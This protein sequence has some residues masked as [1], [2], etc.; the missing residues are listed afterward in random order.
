M[1]VNRI[2]VE[3]SMDEKLFQLDWLFVLE[4]SVFW[5]IVQ[6]DSVFVNDDFLG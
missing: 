5:L 6:I 3:E 2:N 4:F 1:N